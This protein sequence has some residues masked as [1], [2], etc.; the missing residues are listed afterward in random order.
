MTLTEKFLQ[1]CEKFSNKIAV[2]DERGSITYS[3]LFVGSRRLAAIFRGLGSNK[4][5]GICLPSSQEFAASYFAL[6]LNRQVPVL[7]NPLLSPQ[8]VGYI[9]KDASLDTVLTISL[10]KDLLGPLVENC[11]Y[12]DKMHS[13]TH[14]PSGPTTFQTGEKEDTAAIFYTSGT[15][16][17]PKGVIL[18]HRNIL[19]NMEGCAEP[20]NFTE[21]DIF[22]TP[23]PLFHA[24]AFTVTM[25]LP[26]LF[27]ARVIYVARFSGHKVLEHIEK[28]R[29][30]VLLAVASMYRA[31]LRSTRSSRYDTSSMRLAATGGEPVPMDVIN[32]FKATF[33]LPLLEG[34]GLTECSPIVSVNSPSDYKFGTAGKPLPNLQVKIVDENGS[35]LPA[36]QDGE[37]WV[38]GPNIMKG[39]LNQPDLT[40][41]TITPDGWFKTGD[42]GRLDDDGFLKITGR[43]KEII[44]IGGENVS[45]VEI[46]DVLS[47]HP[48][49]FE[50]AVVGVPD[51]LR[52]EVPKACIVLHDNERVTEDE[53]KVFCHDKLP[54]YKIPK[55]FEFRKEL[56][57][58]PTGKILRR[59]LLT[60]CPVS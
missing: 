46:E 19:S 37:I 11:V 21:D 57:H 36:N 28:D 18:S 35:T 14:T 10:F 26:I 22:I 5:I 13:T 29:V 47:H 32:S 45:P 54:H 30:T 34:Y 12:L 20:F 49:V 42:F 17:N 7:I 56:P 53:L 48:K 33:N 24:F 52:G 1:G 41:E 38:K 15:S 9:V 44:I 16:A 60:S 27:G 6:L 3:G 59:A 4:N 58:G 43:K 55:Y 40:K 39:Y 51:K 25:A 50:V 8:Q 31:L 2:S 23:L